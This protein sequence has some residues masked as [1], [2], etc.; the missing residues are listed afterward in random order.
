[1]SHTRPQS[2]KPSTTRVKPFAV[3]LSGRVIYQADT[4][5][6]VAAWRDA[7]GAGVLFERVIESRKAVPR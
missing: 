3:L 6:A 5:A 7:Y 4:L 2:V 1:M